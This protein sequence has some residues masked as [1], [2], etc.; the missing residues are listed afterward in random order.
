MG[1][2]ADGHPLAYSIVT[3]GAKGSATI[4]DPTPGAFTYV[5]NLNAN[6]TD[7]FTFKA[8]DGTVDSNTATITVTITPVNDAPAASDGTVA[9]TAGTSVSGSLVATDVDSGGLTHTI[10]TNGTKGTAVIT[11][12]AT[13]AY[14]YTANAGS[15]GMDTFT[16]KANDAFLD[17]NEAAITVTITGPVCAA[18]ISASVSVSQG[19]LKLNKKTGRYAQTVTLRN[20][21][22]VV[23]APVSLVLGGLS[24]NGV[25]VNATGTTACAAPVGSPYVNVDVGT[26]SAFGPR[27]RATVTLEFTN[28]SGQPITY[29]ARILAGVS[30]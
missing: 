2:D 16:F 3:N 25:L 10:V 30:R 26:D 4:N 29:T 27:E 20:D 24:S 5:P 11:N 9:V 22:G 23:S 6:G 13:G 17:S 14:T 21:G 19:P 8:N 18:D 28:P 15:S 7:T 12:T 1:T